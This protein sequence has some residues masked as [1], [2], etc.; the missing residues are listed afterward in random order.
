MNIMI[1]TLQ[2]VPDGGPSSQLFKMLCD[3]LIKRGHKIT[4]IAAV[5]HYPSG[6]VPQ[7]FRHGWIQKTEEDFLTIFRIRLPS[8]NRANLFLRLLQFI[9]YQLGAA[10]VAAQ[11]TCD[12]VLVTNP[13]IES[14]LPFFVSVTLKKHPAIFFVADV[15]PNVGIELG[16]FR[17][18]TVIEIVKL[19]ERHCLLAA[20]YVWI[21][22]E[23]FSQPLEELGI[24]RNKQALI[25]GWVDTEFIK[26][27]EKKSGFALEYGLTG[28]FVVLYAGNIG[29]SQGWDTILETAAILSEIDPEV[30]LVLVGDGSARDSLIEQAQQQHLSNIRFIPFQDFKRVP[31]VLASADIALISLQTNMGSGS[32]PSKLFSYL[33]SGRSILA[34]VDEESDLANLIKKAGA[35]I[36]VSPNN[37][38][39]LAAT[40]CEMKANPSQIKRFGS[41]GRAYAVANHS[42]QHAAEEIENL[43]SRAIKK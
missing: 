2:Y 37:A 34:V 28:Y 33:A 32:I 15:Y 6:Q 10:W 13:A 40:I 30:L 4:M 38:K 7:S 12:V 23:S 16:I 1:I 26:P 19:L 43:C 11:Q 31:E 41:Y 17:H 20:D 24:A 18:R 29:F 14:F 35:G 8:I 36:I 5:P 25:Y 27:L 22:S 21:F 3:E 9:I 42:P 39:V